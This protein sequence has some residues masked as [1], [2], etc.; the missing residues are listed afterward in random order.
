MLKM[1]R[2][3]AAIMAVVTLLSCFTLAVSAKNVCSEIS[4]ETDSNGGV[5]TVFY[6]TTKNTKE[7]YV[8][9]KMTKGVMT[10]QFGAFPKKIYDYYE[11]IVYG[12]QSNG[13]YKQISKMNIKN[14]DDKRIYFEGYTEYKI[15]VYSWKTDTINSV[16][17]H[18]M[19]ILPGR[20]RTPLTDVRWQTIPEWEISK[21]AS[22]VTLCR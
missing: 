21:T 16:G 7:R 13:A 2:L 15:K 20:F 22:G 12:K 17:K 3:S 19:N 14:Q 11:V 5:N 8:K 10:D 4:G 1:K 9:M 6:V 18:I